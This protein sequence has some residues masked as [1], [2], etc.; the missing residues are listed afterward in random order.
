LKNKASREEDSLPGVSIIVTTFN[1]ESTIDE[2]LRSILELDYPEHLLEVIMIDGGSTDSTTERAKA[3]PVKLV[4]SQLN[5]P[6]AY[7]L[8]LKTVENE[9]IGLIDSDAKVEKGWLRKLVKH[10]DDPKAAGASGTVETWNKDKL[11]PRAIG[12]ELSYRYQRLPNTV[13]RV[14]TMNLLLK[15]KVTLEIGD[16]DEALPTQYDTDIGARIADAG[17]RIAFD[18]EA[19]C[20]HFH[21]PTLRT[22][23]KQQ[24]KYGQNTWK[25]YFKHP[26][27]A[28]GDKITD[29]WMNIQ[30]I[31]YGVAAILLLISVV[32]NFHL[33]PSLIFLS[34]VII[35]TL[36]YIVSAAR[37]SY[38][39]H[40]P[41]AMYLIVIYFI[42]A[43]AW[44][45]GGATSLIHTALT[46]GE[47]RKS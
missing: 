8:V 21:R 5:P 34:L 1:S 27:L 44:T 2:C 36:H 30:P 35:T 19:I 4:Y 37:I 10:L 15:K 11:V 20:Y 38:I 25:L 33:I 7:N 18:S 29:W 16:F 40:D 22:F 13:E 31:L 26:R 23:F 9:I 14:A 47:E 41:S 45:L 24:Y 32:T 43:F 42:R 39:F 28:K 46:G 17:Y 6:A 3:Y 12:Y